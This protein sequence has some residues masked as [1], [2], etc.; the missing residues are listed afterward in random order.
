MINLFFKSNRW[1]KFELKEQK[2]KDKYKVT[3]DLGS[4]V[5]KR[6]AL[7]VTKKRNEI[8]ICINFNFEEYLKEESSDEDD[9]KKKTYVPEYIN[10]PI[11]KIDKVYEEL[12]NCIESNN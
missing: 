12:N 10:V 5:K 4:D 7:E 11:E 3:K 6:N 9:Q 8:N 1:A 2:I